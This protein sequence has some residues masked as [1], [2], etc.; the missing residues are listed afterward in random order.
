MLK[1]P[2]TAETLK[3]IGKQ[4]KGKSAGEIANDLLG[5]GGDSSDGQSAK[6]KAKDLLRQFMAPQ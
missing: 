2:K 4:F 5:N 1:D 6:S 3:E